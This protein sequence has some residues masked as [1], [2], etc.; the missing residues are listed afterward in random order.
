MVSSLNRISGKKEEEMVSNMTEINAQT[1]SIVDSGVNTVTKKLT[2]RIQIKTTKQMHH[3]FRLSKNLYNRANKLVYQAFHMPV[4]EKETQKAGK[5]IRYPTLNK[6]LKETLDYQVLPAQTAQQNLMLVDRNWTSFFE[7]M[8]DW[9]IHP[10]KYKRKPAP[11]GL[12]PENAEWLLIFTNQQIRIRDNLLLFP[13]RTQLPPVKFNPERVG[14]LKQVRLLPRGRHSIVEIVYEIKVTR[15]KKELQNRD[16]ILAIDLGVRNIVCAVNNCGLR[17][18]IVKGGAVKWV[19]QYYNKQRAKYQKIKTKQGIEGD[20]KR[21]ERLNRVRNNKIENLFHKLSRVIVSYCRNNGIVTIVI[22]YNALWKQKVRLGK[23]N[24]QSFVNIPLYRLV[25]KIQYKAELEG[26]EVCLIEENHTSK[27]SFLDSEP[28][29]H[30]EK[31]MGKRGVYVPKKAGG[32]GGIHHGLFQTADGTIINSDVNGAYNILHKAFPEAIAADG[33]E[34]LGLIPYSV[35]FAELEQLAN[36]KSPQDAC[37]KAH[38]ADGLEASGLSQ[39]GRLTI[40]AKDRANN[41][42]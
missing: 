5:R 38:I 28:I 2:E 16:R 11:P 18:F 22:G 33:I 21:L 3:L 13:E 10:E 17:P 26:I 29:G 34:G 20:T 31:Y 24:N 40:P 14:K 30:H 35:T 1:N 42:Y 15:P 23:K 37:P 4:L 32:K 12:K 9:K 25:Q 7:A 6:E 41:F 39:R 36:L 27:C 19:N 8:A